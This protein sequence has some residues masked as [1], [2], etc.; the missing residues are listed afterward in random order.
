L[1]FIN[2]GSQS[3]LGLFTLAKTTL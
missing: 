3:P 2:I 1:I